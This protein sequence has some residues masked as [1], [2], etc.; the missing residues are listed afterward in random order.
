MQIES[1]GLSL[2]T[3]SAI[4]PSLNPPD[5]INGVNLTTCSPSQSQ[6]S[7]FFFSLY[8]VAVAQGGHKPCVQAF[9]A[10]QFDGQDSKETKAKSSFFN[11][12]YLGLVGGSATAI[13]FL[14]Y[15]QDNLNW[16]LGFGIPCISMVIALLVFL[17][18]NRTYRHTIKGHVENPFFRIGK[19]FASA[20]W[21]WRANDH[22]VILGNIE[23]QGT[24]RPESS[25][26]HK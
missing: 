9:G 21:N 4:L 14:N 2:L 7:L 5:C 22:S 23:A 6:V 24:L 11:W 10:D 12:W 15:I 26:H 17:M 19:V 1:Q 16:A 25:Q 8:I 18:G 3:L 13:L 20:A